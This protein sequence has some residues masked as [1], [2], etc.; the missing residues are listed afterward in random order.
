[1]IINYSW[2]NEKIYTLPAF[3]GLGIFGFLLTAVVVAVQKQSEA[4]LGRL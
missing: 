1:M 3:S 2:G 4:F